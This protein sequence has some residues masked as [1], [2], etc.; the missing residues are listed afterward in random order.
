[1]KNLK[2]ERFDSA[3][4]PHIRFNYT[5]DIAYNMEEEVKSFPSED[6]EP[7]AKT[8]LEIGLATGHIVKK[9]KDYYSAFDP[10]TSI[11]KNKADVMEWIE[12]QQEEK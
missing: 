6:D 11:G 1:M 5:G 7:S 10:E 9:G 3:T 2:Q 8:L 4:T 12:A